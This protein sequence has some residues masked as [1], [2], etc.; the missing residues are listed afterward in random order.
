MSLFEFELLPVDEI[1]PWGEEPNLT[2]SWFALT[3]GRFRMRVGAQTLFEYSDQIGSLWKIERLNAEFQ[4]AAFARDML[5]CFSAAVTP[6]PTLIERV[7]SD[8]ALMNELQIT[9]PDE[10]Q[11]D[12]ALSQ[13]YAAWRWLGERSPWTSYLVAEPRIHFLRI[14]NDVRICW[15]N[16]SRKVDELPVW[17]AEH[18]FHTMSVDQFSQECTDFRDRLLDA[19]ACRI[20]EI[21]SGIVAPRIPVNVASLRDQ[22]EDW[23]KEFLTYFGSYKP[24]ISW[25]EAE[26]ALRAIAQKKGIHL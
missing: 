22:H 24:D 17:T 8:D 1:V 23:E 12:K 11:H 14:G 18:G 2:L 4:I 19:M 3:D 15:D 10:G 21:E 9:E 25:L 26:S 5:G 16:R 20:G 7:A 13:D 6:L